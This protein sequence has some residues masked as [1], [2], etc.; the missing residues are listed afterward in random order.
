LT[1]LS[2]SCTVAAPTSLSPSVWREKER[3]NVNK[4]FAH[5]LKICAA[6]SPSVPGRPRYLLDPYHPLHRPQQPIRAS[7][8]APLCPKLT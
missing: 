5:Q 4:N 6:A 3:R 7:P 1:P 8:W 2:S